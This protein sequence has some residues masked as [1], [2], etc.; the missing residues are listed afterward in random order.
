MPD[1]PEPPMIVL[2]KYSDM[3]IE[4]GSTAG[5]FWWVKWR[6]ELWKPLDPDWYQNLCVRGTLLEVVD[7]PANSPAAVALIEKA[8]VRK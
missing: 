4:Q 5:P 8:K 2:A 6:G 3:L 1:L 7:H